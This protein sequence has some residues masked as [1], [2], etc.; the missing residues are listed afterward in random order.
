ML[1]HDRQMYCVPRGQISM[2]HHNCFGPF[3]GRSFNSQHLVGNPQQRVKRWL[4]G[5]S[6]IYGYVPV[7]YF[8]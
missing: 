1:L 4:N 8:L 3:Q 7:Q 2:P 6:A 5:F